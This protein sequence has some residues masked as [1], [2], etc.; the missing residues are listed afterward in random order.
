MVSIPLQNSLEVAQQV[1]TSYVA[2]NNNGMVTMITIN[3]IG[4]VHNF[5]NCTGIKPAIV[6]LGLTV[7]R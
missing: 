3:I 1:K 7:V 4:K 5:L 6:I 2:T